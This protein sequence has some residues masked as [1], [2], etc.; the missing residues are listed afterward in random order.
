MRNDVMERNA[1]ITSQGLTDHDISTIQQWLNNAGS[2][3][4][5]TVSISS[6]KVGPTPRLEASRSAEHIRLLAQ[7]STP[8]PPIIVHRKSM[9]LIDG[10]HRLEAARLMKREEIAVRFFDGDDADAFALAVQANVEHGL[11]LSLAE[12]RMAAARL[13]G[14]HPHWSDRLIARTT[15][16]SHHTV[17]A[18]RRY[19]AGHDAELRRRIGEDGKSRPISTVEGRRVAAEVI[20]DNPGASLRR[21]SELA[22]ISPGTVRDVRSRLDRGEDPVPLPRVAKSKQEA[23]SGRAATEPTVTSEP[24]SE[25][26]RSSPR[27]TPTRDKGS[28]AARKIQ[29]DILQRLKKDPGLRFNDKGRSILRSIAASVNEIDIWENVL[30]DAPAHCHGSLAKLARANAKTWDDLAR[31]L[32]T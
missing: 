24:V 20:R 4:A 1:Q 22:G 13:V 5:A 32:D 9:R 12:R 2:I 26:E 7:A 29:Y 6:I 27:T 17:G 14:S 16:L 3:P 8:L 11:P 15:G 30:L 10:A 18:E 21:I 19:A 23:G 28:E 31:K 25:K